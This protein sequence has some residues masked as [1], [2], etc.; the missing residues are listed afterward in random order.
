[1]KQ[2]AV[3]D[4]KKGKT[5]IVHVDGVTIAPEGVD[6]NPSFDVIQALTGLVQKK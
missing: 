3:N 5:P 1:M 2:Q 4:I 6:I